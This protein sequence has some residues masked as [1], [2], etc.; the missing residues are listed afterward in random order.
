MIHVIFIFLFGVH[1]SVVGLVFAFMFLFEFATLFSTIEILSL[2]TDVFWIM[3]ENEL[4][5]IAKLKT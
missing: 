2:I 5:F 4:G 1:E 3:G